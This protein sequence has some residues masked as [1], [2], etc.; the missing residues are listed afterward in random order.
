MANRVTFLNLEN[1]AQP[2]PASQTEAEL[3]PCALDFFIQ[4]VL[5]PRQK[6]VIMLYYYQKQTLRQIATQLGITESTACRT[7]KRACKRLFNYIY[8]YQ[9]K[10][11]FLHENTDL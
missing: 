10:E 4:N 6:Q 7:K 9:R 1:I 3:S 8:T 11:L 5:T 2:A